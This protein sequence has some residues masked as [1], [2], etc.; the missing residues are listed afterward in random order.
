MTPETLPESIQLYEA[1]SRLVAPDLD[2]DYI[3]GLASDLADILQTSVA[4]CVYQPGDGTRYPLVITP[5]F[6][7]RHGRPRVKDGSVWEQHAISGVRAPNAAD[8]DQGFAFY[9]TT[10]F[11]VSWIE[12]AAYPIRLGGGR[13]TLAAS[14]V[15]EHWDAGQGSGATLAILLRAISHHLDRWAGGA[16]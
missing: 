5:L 7:L 3:D 13:G 14:Y 11:L 15:A 4:E 16:R 10:G 9:D 12:H 1:E 8:G 2:F 6:M